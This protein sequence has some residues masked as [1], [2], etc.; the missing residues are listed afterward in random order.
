MAGSPDLALYAV[1]PLARMI[2]ARR[3][4]QHHHLVESPCHAPLIP[5]PPSTRWKGSAQLHCPVPP[6]RVDPEAKA[7]EHF[8]SAIA[9]IASAVPSPPPPAS[10][11]VQASQASPAGPP[12]PQPWRAALNDAWSS[13]ASAGHGGGRLPHRPGLV[14]RSISCNAASH[15]SAGAGSLWE[16]DAD[17]IVSGQEAESASSSWHKFASGLDGKG[18]KRESLSPNTSLLFFFLSHHFLKIRFQI[19]DPRPQTPD[20]SPFCFK[21]HLVLAHTPCHSYTLAHTPCSPSLPLTSPT[22]HISAHTY[23]FTGLALPRSSLY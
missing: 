16:G 5:L 22:V 23:L 8:K 17:G 1:S 15:W 13:E 10:P 3:F 4:Q 21:S 6:L 12:L 7:R 11:S 19:P 14:S 9:P 20:L 18:Y 2:F